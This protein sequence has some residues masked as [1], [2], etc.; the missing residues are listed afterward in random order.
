MSLL[1]KFFDSNRTDSDGWNQN[2]REALVDLLVLAMY[3]DNELNLSEDAILQA[4]IDNFQWEG[5]SSVEYY[6]DNAI[7][8]VRAIRGSASSVDSL[9]AFIAERLDTYEARMT[10]A[11][12][13]ERLL[14]SDGKADPEKAFLEKVQSALQTR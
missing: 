2:Q 5:E 14:A 13:C 10:A 12:I 8:R 11:G 4:Q 9:I 3:V 7:G 1:D 6:V